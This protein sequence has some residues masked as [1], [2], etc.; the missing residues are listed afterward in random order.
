MFL[1]S[2]ISVAHFQCF[3]CLASRIKMYEPIHL[4]PGNKDGPAQYGQHGQHSSTKAL[5]KGFSVRKLQEQ[6][7]IKTP[8]SINGQSFIIDKC[9]NCDIYILD[10][11]VQVTMRLAWTEGIALG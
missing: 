6:N 11:G 9:E 10:Y 5:H 3:A 8:G 4:R 2:I 1:R 7:K